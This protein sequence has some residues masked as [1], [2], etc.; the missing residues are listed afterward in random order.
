MEPIKPGLPSP[1]VAPS[2]S[3]RRRDFELPTDADGNNVYVVTV[4]ASDGNG[5]T[6]SQT[7]NVTVTAVNDNNPL[8]TSPD[9]VNVQEN[10]TAVLTVTATDA[11]VPPQ[12]VTITIVGG[13][14]QSKF[15]LSSSGALSFISPPDFETPTDAN[16]DNVYVVIV[17]ASDGSAD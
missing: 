16:G 15:A 4:Q 8:F 5:G 2:R 9:S 17:Q 10:M 3:L 6:T 14:D 12:T 13:A 11:D 7:I 1:A